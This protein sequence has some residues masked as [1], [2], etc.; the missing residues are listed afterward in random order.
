MNSFYNRVLISVASTT[1]LHASIFYTLN[2][3]EEPQV[4][5]AKTI[6]IALFDAPKIEEKKEIK[7]KEEPKPEPQKKPKK[8]PKKVVKQEV[9]QPKP[10]PIVKQEPKPV[11]K[12]QK[13]VEAKPLEETIIEAPLKPFMVA[14][15]EPLHVRKTDHEEPSQK[16]TQEQK[17]VSKVAPNILEEYL[18]KV[19]QMI[20]K[21]LRYPPL[22]KRLR[23]EGES[24]VGF[25]I[26]G[27]GGVVESSCEVKRSSGHKT[28]DR[29]AI[30]TI[31][32]VLPFDAPP[33]GKISIIVPIAFNLK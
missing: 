8:P 12:E 27:N 26:L 4:V 14:Q 10:K 22:A 17:E 31:L 28:L 13:V 5:K 3:I 20:Q 23:L 15:D 29:E 19:R 6:E 11:V 24:L 2:E 9:V 32:S 33:S 30:E 18:Y 16:A 1:I 21:N 7:P 25:E